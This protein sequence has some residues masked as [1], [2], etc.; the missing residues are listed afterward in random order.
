MAIDD[1][2]EALKNE[3]MGLK[4]SMITTYVND[5]SENNI[6]GLVLAVCDLEEL[7]KVFLTR[8][9]SSG[10][11]RIDLEIQFRPCR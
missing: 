7:R 6:S 10:S 3:I 11:I 5:I 8:N 4:Q 2:C 9:M 1:V